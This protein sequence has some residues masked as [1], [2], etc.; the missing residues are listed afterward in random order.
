MFIPLGSQ[1]FRTNGKG[2]AP[3]K[4]ETRETFAR[5]CRVFAL[6]LFSLTLGL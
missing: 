5:W 3:Q 4:R 6:F 1:K 2:T